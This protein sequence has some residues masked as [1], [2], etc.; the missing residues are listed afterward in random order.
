MPDVTKTYTSCKAMPFVPRADEAHRS[1]K[2]I[3]ER[4]KPM[5]LV[6]EHL[7]ERIEALFY[8]ARRPFDGKH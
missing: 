3:R 7:I 1:L 2:R 4:R 5:L 8:P 6:I